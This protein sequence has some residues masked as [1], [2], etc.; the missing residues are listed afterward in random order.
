MHSCVM[1]KYLVLL[2]IPLFS[3]LAE[4]TAA[5]EFT[6]EKDKNG[7]KVYTRKVEGSSLKEF[8]GVTAI[9]TSLMSLVALMD[10][11]DSYTKWLHNVTEAKLLKAMN[12]KERVSY[13]VIHAPWPVSDRDAVTYSKI[14][15]HPKTKAVTI[16][17]EGQASG[18]PAQSGKVRVPKLKGF[19]QFIPSSSGWVTVVYQVH[20]EPG[21]SIPDALANSTVVDLPYNT[22]LKMQAI[23]KQEKYQTAK[24]A[25]VQELP[26]K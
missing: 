15:Q 22:L 4:G 17:L 16:Y 26:A 21:G 18:Y 6:L 9:K 14:S 5:N 12:L 2:L 19:W 13:T 10:D 23:V 25:E 24:V 8:K 1:K 20:S 3:L 7:V 11:T